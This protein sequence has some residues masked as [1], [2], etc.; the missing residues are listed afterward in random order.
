MEEA[1]D[2][3]ILAYTQV[4]TAEDTSTVIEVGNSLNG[5]FD[6]AATG[7]TDGTLIETGTD[8]GTPFEIPSVI[9]TA[10]GITR[11]R[12]PHLPGALRPDG[13][14][15]RSLRALGTIQQHQQRHRR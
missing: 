15:P 2:A 7:T 8:R 6:R 10:Y 13:I 12:Q 3:G 1:G 9:S 14:R 11:N 4:L 5:I